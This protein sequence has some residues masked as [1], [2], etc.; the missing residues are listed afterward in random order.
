MEKFRAL[1]LVSLA[2]MTLNSCNSQNKNSTTPQTREAV[3]KVMNDTILISKTQFKIVRNKIGVLD[4]EIKE[5]NLIDKIADSKNPI[6]MIELGGI[7]TIA[8]GNNI[9]SS[10]VPNECDYFYPLG[11]DNKV[12]MKKEGILNL[13]KVEK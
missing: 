1:I 4:I 13:R 10:S 5:N 9:F 6:L 7:Y 3:K 8:K 12:I 11:N 2:I